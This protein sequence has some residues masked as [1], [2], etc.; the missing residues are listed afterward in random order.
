MAKNNGFFFSIKKR[1]SLLSLVFSLKLI[2]DT[3][4]N[5]FALMPTTTSI[6]RAMVI[7]LHEA[8]HIQSAIAARLNCSQST[9]CRTIRKYESTGSVADLPRMER[10]RSTTDRENRYIKRV[11]LANRFMNSTRLISHLPCHLRAKVNNRTIRRRLAEMGIEARWPR[12][13]PALTPR[14]I[15][16]R[17]EWGKKIKSKGLRR[18]WRKV[19]F[20]D[21][22]KFNLYQSDGRVWVWRRKGEELDQGC[23]L[24]KHKHPQSVMAWGSIS[25]KGVGDLKFIEGKMDGWMYSQ[26]LG[27]AFLP[28]ANCKFGDDFLLQDDNDS[29][30]WSRLVAWW[31]EQNEIETIDWPASS[32][33]INLIEHVW[34]YVKR[35]I[36]KRPNPPQNR[37]ELREAIAE[38]WYKIDIQFIRSLSHC[39]II[40]VDPPST[41][42]DGVCW[43]CGFCN[44]Y[45]VLQSCKNNSDRAYQFFFPFF[46]PLCSWP[47]HSGLWVMQQQHHNKHYL[48]NTVILWIEFLKI[49]PLFPMSGI[50][51]FWL[52]WWLCFFPPL[53]RFWAQYQITL[54]GTIFFLAAAN[55]IWSRGGAMSITVR[56]VIFLFVIYFYLFSCFAR[57]Q[58]QSLQRFD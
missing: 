16:Q 26:I 57:C 43:L 11:A 31:K 51:L 9:V 20:T 58:F 2:N 49:L 28:D 46:I 25:W 32:P 18:F 38:E 15:K 27:D 40:R 23:I 22:S 52:I 8:G 34:D 41:D 12:Q 55:I 1:K 53:T 48:M 5:S 10:P 21:E 17:L 50:H 3:Q 24:K 4:F 33:A 37:D 14:H 29:K 6:D 30:H 47:S 13:K 19:I 39:F 56:A 44:G 54:C 7:A 36:A 42:A 35:A 45:F